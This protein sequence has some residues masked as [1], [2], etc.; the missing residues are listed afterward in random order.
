MKRPVYTHLFRKYVSYGF[1]IIIF[2]NPGVH[3]ETP[4][5]HTS[6]PYSNPNFLFILLQYC[7]KETI[8]GYKKYGGKHFPALPLQ[9][10]VSPMPKTVTQCKFHTRNHKYWAPTY[11]LKSPKQPGARELST[12]ESVL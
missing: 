11:K 1:P 8:L 5:R 10:Q 12:P 3:Y 7:S 9:P 4:C 6:F 2:C